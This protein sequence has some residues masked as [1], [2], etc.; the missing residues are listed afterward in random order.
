MEW[1]DENNRMEDD[2]RIVKN[3]VIRKSGN[4]ESCL[5]KREKI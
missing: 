5:K 2:R 3:G 4:D 1:R